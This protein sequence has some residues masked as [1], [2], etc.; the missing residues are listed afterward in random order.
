MSQRDKNVEIFQETSKLCKQDPTLK[1]VIKESN[2]KQRI[3][4]EWDEVEKVTEHAYTQE[5]QIV[6][7]KKRSFE[8]AR[9]YQGK[10]VCVHN[11]ASATNPGGGV[12][13]GSN[14]QEESLC[15]CSTLYFN[16]TQPVNMSGFYGPHRS[17]HSAVYNDDCIY[18]P[19]VMVIREDGEGAKLLKEKDW[20]PVNILTCAAPNLRLHPANAMN[21]GGAAQA[22]SLKPSELKELHKKRLS[23]ILDIARLE[24]NEVVI[25]GAF[26][27]GAFQNPPAVVVQAFAEI[28][29]E[30]KYD[31]ET[32]EFAVFC[33]A[34]DT[35]NYDAFRRRFG[36]RG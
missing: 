31:F 33:T 29:P 15:R 27:C 26:G 36:R 14:A 8:A 30:Y 5:A 35:E 9:A 7:S 11:F 23:R 28:L 18:T 12:T 21:P 20:Y 4:Y 3:I 32:I 13:K 34:R 19:D 10:K 17:L 25:L 22:V 16:L 1:Q 6:V 2:A 24:G